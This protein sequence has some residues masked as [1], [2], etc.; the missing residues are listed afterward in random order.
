MRGAVRCSCG[1][2]LRRA[3]TR[4]SLAPRCAPARPRLTPPLPP[5]PRNLATVLGAAHQHQLRHM[6]RLQQMRREAEA[7]AVAQ[8]AW[9]ER[10][11]G[12]QRRLAEFQ[13]ALEKEVRWLIPGT[14]AISVA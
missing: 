11:A 9:K 1:A 6:R 12:E 7:A 14:V 4:C 2:L 10:S 13:A 3:R 8:A 5:P